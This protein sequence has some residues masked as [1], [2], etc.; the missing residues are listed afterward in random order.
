MILPFQDYIARCS[1]TT[2]SVVLAVWQF[3]ICWHLCFCPERRL[4][5]LSFQC[6]F[7]AMNVSTRRWWLT[8]IVQ[9]SRT[10][11]DLR[12]RWGR[13]KVIM[14]TFLMMLHV[15]KGPYLLYCIPKKKHYSKP[16][17]INYYDNYRFDSHNQRRP[18]EECRSHKTSFWSG[19]LPG[20]P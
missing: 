8:N 11:L 3:N 7:R 10:S 20:V 6:R 9:R 1:Q 13:G 19:S 18:F 12:R 4:A 5:A 15:S 14:A 16:I 2:T 17:T